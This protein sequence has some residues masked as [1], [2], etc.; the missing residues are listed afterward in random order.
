MTADSWKSFATDG[1]PQVGQ[2]VLLLDWDTGVCCRE[3]HYEAKKDVGWTHWTEF[4]PPAKEDGLVKWWKDFKAKAPPD[5]FNRCIACGV[6]DIVEEAWN[7][8]TRQANE[9]QGAGQNKIP[10]RSD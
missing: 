4:T 5:V 6:S 1:P 8:A 3:E 7:E 9:K 2:D 10:H